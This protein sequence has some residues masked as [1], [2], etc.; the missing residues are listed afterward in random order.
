MGGF[1]GRHSTGRQDP[2]KLLNYDRDVVE[3]GVLRGVL[4]NATV[5]EDCSLRLGT[6]HA[7]SHLHL[8]SP[9]AVSFP[10]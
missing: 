10:C 5:V 7:V 4:R 9:T 3:I 8:L 6:K 2:L 1:S